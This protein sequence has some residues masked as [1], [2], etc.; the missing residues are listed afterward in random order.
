[1]NPFIPMHLSVRMDAAATAPRMIRF[2]ARSS[3]FHDDYDFKF[4]ITQHNTMQLIILA[5]TEDGKP[6]NMLVKGAAFVPTIWKEQI[7]FACIGITGLILRQ[8]D[9]NVFFEYEDT[10]YTT[11][12]TK[13]E[14]DSPSSVEVLTE[15]V[16]KIQEL[17][18]ELVSI[19]GKSTILRFINYAFEFVRKEALS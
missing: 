11:D 19:H 8:N 14:E 6:I 4:K 3:L 15:I 2:R 10:T 17:L 1:M 9:V 7:Q 16:D 18:D 5:P 13:N 12:I